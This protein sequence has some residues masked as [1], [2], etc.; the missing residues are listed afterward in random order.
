MARVTTFGLDLISTVFADEPLFWGEEAWARLGRHGKRG[1]QKA[2]LRGGEA[3]FE[4]GLFGRAYAFS[5]RPA[6]IAL[7]LTQIRLIWPDARRT[8]TRCTFGRNLRLVVLV[9][10]VPMPPLFFACPLRW[11]IEPVVGRLPVIAQILAMSEIG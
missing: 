1:Q 11:M 7:A 2:A 10:C 5:M 8:R 3:A 9:T 4:S 6:L